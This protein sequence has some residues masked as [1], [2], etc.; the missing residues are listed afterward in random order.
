MNPSGNENLGLVRAG[1]QS[2][3]EEKCAGIGIGVVTCMDLCHDDDPGSPAK[4]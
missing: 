2:S 4:P 3:R 1:E